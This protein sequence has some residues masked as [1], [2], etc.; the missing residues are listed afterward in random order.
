MPTCL[1]ELGLICSPE[2]Q[3]KTVQLEIFN[4]RRKTYKEMETTR[5]IN[6]VKMQDTINIQKKIHHRDWTSKLENT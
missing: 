4:N 5:K 6:A 2:D 3:E 1:E